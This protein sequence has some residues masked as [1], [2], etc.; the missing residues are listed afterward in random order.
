MG[1]HFE[2]TKRSNFVSPVATRHYVWVALRLE[3]SILSV[4]SPFA[5][6]PCLCSLQPLSRSKP[7]SFL[8][9][10]FATRQLIS[11]WATYAQLAALTSTLALDSARPLLTRS[12]RW[13]V[14][15]LDLTRPFGQSRSVFALTPPLPSLPEPCCSRLVL[16][17]FHLNSVP[18]IRR[19]ADGL[20]PICSRFASQAGVCEVLP[21]LSCATYA[22]APLQ[23]LLWAR[24]EHV[25]KLHQYLNGDRK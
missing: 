7:L 21:Q 25:L 11:P 3:T 1:S 6:A 10:P 13:L 16:E 17:H 8:G 15:L 24:R 5:G 4:P 23:T 20:P 9:V 12:R 22:D 19:V 14:Q 18:A 2:W